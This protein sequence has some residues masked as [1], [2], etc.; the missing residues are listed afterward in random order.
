MNLINL[1][2]NLDLKFKYDFN[3]HKHELK[4]LITWFLSDY[5]L[6]D[7]VYMIVHVSK[8]VT[9]LDLCELSDDH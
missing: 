1:I 8:I 9:L 5:T 6:S 7:G 3:M 4:L 2:V